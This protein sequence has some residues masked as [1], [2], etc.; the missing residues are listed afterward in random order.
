MKAKFNMKR[1]FE[2]DGL[3][4]HLK[5]A[6]LVPVAHL[7]EI[8]G[9]KWLVTDFKKGDCLLLRALLGTGSQCGHAR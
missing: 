7:S 5:G 8:K 1:L 9:Y 2:L 3:I 4:Y 6:E